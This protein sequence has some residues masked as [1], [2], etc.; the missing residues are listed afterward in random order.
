MV[1]TKGA[2]EQL[3]RNVVAEF[4]ASAHKAGLNPDDAS[5]LSG[6][7]A[8][9]GTVEATPGGGN[10]VGRSSTGKVMASVGMSNPDQSKV[11][12]MGWRVDHIAWSILARYPTIHL[13]VQPVPPRDYSVKIN[14][15]DYPATESSVWRA[16]R[17]S[18]RQDRACWKAAM[19]LVRHRVR[20]R[21][22]GCL[23]FMTAC[24]NRGGH[25]TSPPDRRQAL[26]DAWGSPGLAD[27]LNV[28]C[29]MHRPHR[30]S[31]RDPPPRTSG[32][33]PRPPG[34]RPPWCWDF[35]CWR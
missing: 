24:S 19:Q 5:R 35:G 33:N 15:E 7:L 30:L 31:R 4:T 28:A 11:L 23:Q 9:G 13:V 27:L 20:R 16:P 12:L 2:R 25:S 29:D 18:Q 32:R 14:G 10:L 21:A 17:L 6:A 34:R 1:V 3:V 26:L 8:D 22:A